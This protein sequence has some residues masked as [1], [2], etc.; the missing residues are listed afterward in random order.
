[1]ISL[2]MA[3]ILVI[4]GLSFSP[5]SRGLLSGAV[6]CLY[7]TY[8]CWSSL[9]SFPYSECNPT[10]NSSHA[11]N[12]AISFIIAVFALGYSAFSLAISSDSITGSHS[13]RPSVTQADHEVTLIDPKTIEEGKH[14]GEGEE[15]EKATVG[16][17]PKP[18]TGTEKDEEHEEGVEVK[19]DA[20]D[21]LSNRLYFYL[22]LCM[23]ACYM[24][25]LVTDWSGDAGLNSPSDASSIGVG[26]ESMWVK[27]ISQ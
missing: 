6:I 26:L 22:I 14:T 24:T 2:T 8:L 18:K 3:G 4:A 7:T 25:M 19:G 13:H 27:I 1:M 10:L 12:G 11:F 23:G 21:K 17:K 9:S 16:V 20:G 15:E 5:Y